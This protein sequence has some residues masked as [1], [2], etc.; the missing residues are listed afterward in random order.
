MKV[1]SPVLLGLS[2]AVVGS[3]LTAAQEMPAMP[4][5]LQIAREFI[6]PGKSGAIHDKSESNFVQAM[7]RAKWPTHY[8][9]MNSLSGKLRALYI[10]GYPSFDAWEKDNTAIDKNAAL[11]AELDRDSVA[12]GELLNGMDAAVLY[13]DED[14][15]YRPNPDLSHVRYMEISVYK[16]KPGRGKEWSDLAKMAIDANKKA[17]TSAH[18]ATYEVAYGGG[19]EYVIFSAD[20]SMAEIDT[21]YAEDKQFREAMG[22]DGMKTFHELI[23]DCIDSSD[24]ELFQINPRQSYPPEEWVKADPEFW[25]PKPAAAPAAKPAT[26]AKKP[27]Q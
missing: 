25:K 7:A 18:W 8:V 2:L 19:D 12:D 16:I 9:A 24:S 22:E 27:A 26:A 23:R 4:K 17:G 13:Y 3:S 20:K 11:S 10:T 15:S 21:G 14:T 6:K 5:V 1:I